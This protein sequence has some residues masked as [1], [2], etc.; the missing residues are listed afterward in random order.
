MTQAV[1]P[2]MGV[3]ASAVRG[4]VTRLNRRLR[5]HAAKAKG[6]QAVSMPSARHCPRCSAGDP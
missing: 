1:A 3:L 5:Y 6:W 4:A 2:P